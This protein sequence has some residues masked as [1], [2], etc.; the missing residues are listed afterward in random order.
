RWALLTGPLAL[1]LVLL[2]FL[3]RGSRDRAGTRATSWRGR[4]L[5]TIAATA[6]VGFAVAGPV[7]L[8]LT[9]GL[10]VGA[11]VASRHLGAGNAR[12]LLVVGSGVGIVAGAA[13]LA[14]APWPDPLGYAGDG[15]GPQV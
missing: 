13:L 6:G 10:T 14:R 12:T 2:L 4:G 11:L 7:G 1:L 5:L 15:W 9:A 8:G 3:V